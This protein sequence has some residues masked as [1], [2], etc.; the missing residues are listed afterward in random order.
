MNSDL[1]KAAQWIE[2]ADGIIIAA[3]NGLSMSEDFSILRPSA[4][5]NENFADY[6]RR[7]GIHTPLEG[8]DYPYPDH[9]DFSQ[10]YDRLMRAIHYDKPVSELMKNLLD[11]ARI[12]PFY[13]ITT[14]VEDR[15]VQAGFPENDVFYLEGRLTHRLDHSFIEKKDLQDITSVSELELAGYQQ[16]GDFRKHLENLQK[17]VQAHPKLVILELGVSAYNQFLR[18]LVNQILGFSDQN[19]LIQVNLTPLPINPAFR[20]RVLPLT[21]PLAE[22]I[23]ILKSD[24]K[25]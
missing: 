9:R 3:A 22:T 20:G 4:W 23:S 25:V 16:S 17:F 7:F 18:P 10:Y 14:N 2:Q 6:I 13:V 11:I 8:L 21:G 1:Q 12:K 24:L 19:R 5:F 15:F